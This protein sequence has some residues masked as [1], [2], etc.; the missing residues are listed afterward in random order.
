MRLEHW[1][2]TIPLR[3]RS[4]FHRNRL[5]AEL[6]EELRDHIDR[7]IEDNLTRG[8]SLEEARL[9]ALKKFG[10]PS[11]LRDQTRA[12]WN[13]NGLE[14]FARDARIG[15]RTLSRTPGFAIIAI[16]VTALGVG[17]CV[18]LFTVVRGVLLRP[19]PFP[20]SDRL[21]TL[22]ERNTPTA[23]GA[24]FPYN[25][26]SGGLYDA[27]NKENTTFSSIAIVRGD[28]VDLSA[29]GGQIP[30]RLDSGTVSWNLFQTLGV[31]PLL[32]RGFWSPRRQPDCKRHGGAELEFVET[33]LWR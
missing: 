31:S 6:D 29:S 27:W 15:I 33:A 32:G 7:Q 2:Y 4:L 3:L 9:A 26:V 28:Q 17:A 21:L 16:L 18:S 30:E 8:M 12:T 24:D 1:V 13:W 14:Q 10:N 11:L 22:Y 19:L 23:G 20:E 25:V 5:A